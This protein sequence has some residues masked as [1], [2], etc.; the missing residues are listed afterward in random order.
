MKEFLSGFDLREF[1][2][3]FFVSVIGLTVAYMFYAMISVEG[4]NKDRQAEKIK[5]IINKALVQC[6]ALEG[7]YPGDLRHLEKYGVVF[8]DDKFF[9]DY[10]P[11]FTNSLPP[12][13]VISID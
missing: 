4:T 12:V 6:Y 5:E 1:S 9:Y 7:A 11:L 8:Q 3:T 13:T 2:R 10:S